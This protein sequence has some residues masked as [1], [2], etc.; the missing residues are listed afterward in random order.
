MA[1][2]ISNPGGNGIENNFWMAEK[3]SSFVIL[4]PTVILNFINMHCFVEGGRI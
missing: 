2:L 1:N 4:G 3:K